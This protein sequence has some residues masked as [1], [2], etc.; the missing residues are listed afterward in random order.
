MSHQ[1]VTVFKAYPLHQGQKI[2]IEGSRR[3]G[4]WEVVDIGEH[5]VTLRCPISNRQ[6]TWDRFC[7][8]VEEQE[9]AP[10]PMEE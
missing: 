6:F 3:S 1:K 4:D 5:K 10:W 2:R 8:F 7:Y 9:S